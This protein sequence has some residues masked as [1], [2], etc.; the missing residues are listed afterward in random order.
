M[1]VF[2]EVAKQQGFAPAARSLGLSTSAVSR[3]VIELEDWLGAQL[4]HRTTRQL[5]LTEEGTHYLDRCQQVIADVDSIQRTGAD[6]QAEPQGTLR[7]T[8]PTF[9]AKSWLQTLLPDYLSR[10]T[11]VD[12]DLTVADRFVDL[13]AEGFDLALR[14][15]ELPDSTLVA[16]RLTNINLAL[17]ASPAYL[18]KHGTPETVEDL[19]SHNCLVDTIAGYANR[20]PLL[21]GKKS[22]AINVRG[23]I[24]V[25]SGEI[26]R[27]LA[28]A[29]VGIA[30]LPQ[31]FVLED[32][33]QGRL[34]SFLKSSID[35][36]AGLFAVYPQR[37]Y[38]S[39]TVRSFIDYLANHID[40]L[41]I[42]I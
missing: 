17:V 25:N 1:T 32:I 5:S 18:T 34:R 23:S 38:V 11:K 31:L 2:A 15:G 35:F 39:T 12:L 14:A 30:L 6:A 24:R 41:K 42:Q 13:V 3:C 16:R 7:I 37:K 27:S 19:K 33:H 20:W 9:I 4:F 29:G 40:Q 26:V 28:V 21:D 22:K 36:N 10:H 8:A